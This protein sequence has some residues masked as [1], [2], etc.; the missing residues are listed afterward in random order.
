MRSLKF[1]G[2]TPDYLSS[3]YPNAVSNRSHYP[4]RNALD[5]DIMAR[6]TEIFATSFIPSSVTLWNNLPSDMKS[7]QSL[8]VFKSRILQ[9]FNV[10]DVPKYYLVGDGNMSVLHTRIRNQGSDIN[11]HLYLNHIKDNASC[12]CG[13]QI[14]NAEHYFLIVLAILTR[15]YNYFVIYTESTQLTITFLLYGSNDQYDDVNKQET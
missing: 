9:T 15:E 8:S 1:Y 11:F 12:S 2:L 10:S 7:L 3:I 14:E 6:R 5:R 13:Y 4:L